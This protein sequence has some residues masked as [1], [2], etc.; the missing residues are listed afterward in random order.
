MIVSTETRADN[1]RNTINDPKVFLSDDKVSLSRTKRGDHERIWF[2]FI[3]GGNITELNDPV[4]SGDNACF[5]DL[6]KCDICHALFL[7]PHSL[8]FVI[9][10]EENGSPS[11]RSQGIL[12]QAHL[13]YWW[14]Q[15][16]RH[17]EEDRPFLAINASKILWQEPQ[18]PP[19]TAPMRHPPGWPHNRIFIF[20]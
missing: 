2:N 8:A 14:R 20:S 19:G 9:L 4:V 15:A 7:L 5:L 10:Q 18:R 13:S 6:V 16:Q 1:N 12:G 11:L 3:E 17:P